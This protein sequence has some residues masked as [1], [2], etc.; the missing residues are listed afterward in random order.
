MTTRLAGILLPLVLG[1]AVCPA[2]GRAETIGVVLLHGKRGGPAQLNGLKDTI[3]KAGFSVAAPEMCWS[4][5]RIYD[6]PYPECLT[7]IDQAV[8]QVEGLG[9]TSIVIA[10][11]SLGG[12]AA[13]AYAARH[14]GLTGVVALAPAHAVEFLRKNPRIAQSVTRGE[15]MI[16][17]GKGD[18][19][20]A[21]TDID[22]GTY[23]EVTTTANI[24]VSF[25]GR[26]S[27]AAM[28][29]N[30]ELLTA[31][32]LVVSGRDDSTQRSIPYV[33]A[34][35]PDNP[36]SQR[37]VVSS[38]HRGTPT[39]AATVVVSWLKHLGSE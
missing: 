23:F 31:P 12:N 16:A 37:I 11:M 3:A 10:G 8:A 36:M 25:F 15:E 39:A 2:P 9:A 33:F 17:A 22:N 21:F 30:A 7:E 29:D 19:K 32:L 24:Y 14:R 26:N 5:T 34:R 20:A 6:R 4:R 13:L 18:E 1:A 35:A 27:L 38:D 28:P